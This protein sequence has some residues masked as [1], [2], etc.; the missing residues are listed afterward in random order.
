MVSSNE[1]N[2]KLKRE[3]IM[4]IT[5]QQL[6]DRRDERN[7]AQWD[8]RVLDTECYMAGN[9]P[10]L[11]LNFSRNIKPVKTNRGVRHMLIK[12]NLRQRRSVGARFT[13]SS[14]RV[15]RGMA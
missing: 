9:C 6:Q 11:N 4:S 13:R 12:A 1:V 10:I 15:I 8:W 5:L 14:I 3:N 2:P 7:P